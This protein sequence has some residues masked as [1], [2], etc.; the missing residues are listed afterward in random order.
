MTGNRTPGP[1]EEERDRLGTREKAKRYFG[2][3]GEVADRRAFGRALR[4]GVPPADPAM[5]ATLRRLL[6]DRRN[7]FDRPSAKWARRLLPFLWGA[8]AILRVVDGLTGGSWGDWLSAAAFAALAV[9]MW[10][11]TGWEFRR[12]DRLSAALVPPA[13]SSP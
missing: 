11:S 5:H 12:M 3:A 1:G 13:N 9:F 10:W 6:V 2:L 4:S 7:M 8:G